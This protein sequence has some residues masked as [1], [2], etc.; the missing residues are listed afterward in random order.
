MTVNLWEE[1]I[2]FIEHIPMPGVVF[3]VD[4]G[5]NGV[6]RAVRDNVSSPVS[7]RV[8]EIYKFN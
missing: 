5:V 6:F 1:V 2:E 8:V 7:C 4:L 3:A